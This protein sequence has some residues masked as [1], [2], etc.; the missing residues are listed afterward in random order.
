MTV[1]KPKTIAL[2]AII[3][4]GLFVRLFQVDSVVLGWHSHRQADTYSVTKN[5][6]ANLSTFFLPTYHDLS[7]VQ[8]G[9]PNPKGIRL[10]ELPLYNLLVVLLNNL[11]QL[12]LIISHRLVVIL[13]SLITAYLLYRLILPTK[14]YLAA[15]FALFWFTFLPFSIYY[16]R[17][18][19]PEMISVTLGIGSLYVFKKHPI[20]SA[21]LLSLVML[22]KPF[23]AICL[24]PAFIYIFFKSK[25]TLR[26]FFIT[27]IAF[28]LALIP[29]LLWRN[30]TSLYPQGVP[31][32]AWLFNLSPHPVFPEWW[33]GY[34]LTL[35]NQIEA[36]RPHWWYWLFYKRLVLMILG[37][38][39]VIP[40]IVGL[41]KSHPL[42]GLNRALAL[43]TFL[44][45]AIVAGGNLRHDYYQIFTLPQIALSLGLGFS[46]I[47]KYKK[48]FMAIPLLLILSIYSLYTTTRLIYPN[49]QIYNSTQ[50]HLSQIAAD[51][52]PPN[53]LVIAPAQGDTTYLYFLGRSGYPLEMDNFQS[54]ATLHQQDLYLVSTDINDYTHKVQKTGKVLWTGPNGIIIKIP[55]QP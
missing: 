29:I 6:A 19:L 41:L 55:Y 51:Y 26:S 53:A 18:V 36:F 42:V 35:I 47:L 1:S 30:L 39:L 27:V 33:R 4:L 20:Y 37:G 50:L 3:V 17:S 28:G 10:V 14:D 8:S 49:Y 11:T 44:Y 22:I 38:G 15:I 23:F 54:L 25:P 45:F 32:N 34:N 9:L 48:R 13:A 5:L 31:S 12:P 40:Y 16:S 21:L 2:V 46:A 7:H 52:V 43:G 24:L